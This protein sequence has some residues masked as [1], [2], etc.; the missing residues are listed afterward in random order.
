[1]SKKKK[2][3]QKGLLFQTGVTP[4]D[5]RVMGGCFSFYET[6]GLPLNVIFISFQEKDCIPDWID[7]YLTALA[8]GMEHGRILSKLE[9]A[10]SDSFGKEFCDVIISRLDK[11]FSERANQK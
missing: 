5:K 8:A 6:Y 10:I 1:M 7:F 11:M 2:N 9:E 3:K 4:D